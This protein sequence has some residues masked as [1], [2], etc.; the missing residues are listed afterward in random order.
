MKKKRL[1]CIQL[2]LEDW[3]AQHTVALEEDSAVIVHICI[4]VH[5]ICGMLFEQ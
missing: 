5:K 1:E 3:S 4:P 2:C